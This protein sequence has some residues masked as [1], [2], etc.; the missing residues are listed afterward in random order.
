MF[1][2]PGRFHKLQPRVQVPIFETQSVGVAELVQS[3]E[4]E[5]GL[6]VVQT[7]RWDLEIDTISAAPLALA[8]PT[9]HSF[10]KKRSIRWAEL[11]NVPLIGVGSKTA[12]RPIIDDEVPMRAEGCRCR[13]LIR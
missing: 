9:K 10:A 7:N 1:L 12:I 3:G 6:S 4:V 2:D 13:R 8:C 11:R 5:F